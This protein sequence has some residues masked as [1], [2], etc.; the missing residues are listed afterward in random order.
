VE[1]WRKEEGAQ[2]MALFH[3]KALMYRGLLDVAVTE[4]LLANIMSSFV[5]FLR[6]APEKT[7]SPA[8]W[9]LHFQRMVQPWSPG[10]MKGVAIA[11]EEIRRS[12]DGV[13]NLLVDAG[14]AF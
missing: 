12:G 10:G 3:M 6:D 2:A 11:K 13:M 1:E 14:M 9:M 7:E 5:R 4:P 8:E